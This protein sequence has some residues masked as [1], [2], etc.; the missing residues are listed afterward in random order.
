MPTVVQASRFNTLRNRVNAILGTSTSST[1]TSGYGQGTTSNAVVGTSTAPTIVD[2]DKIT[3]QDYEDLYIDIVRS[4]YHQV[5]NSYVIDDFVVGDFESNPATADKI[6]EAY[7]TGL[8]GLATNLE[9]DKFL[10]DPAQ[11]S[12]VGFTDSNG[13]DMSST[14]IGSTP[15]N[16]TIDHIFTMT[17]PTEN[18]RR[19]FFNS[20]GQVRFQ[21]NVEYTGSQAKT[22][23]WQTI[24]A[25]MG[26]ISFAA[27]STFSNSNV[28]TGYPVG[29]YSLTSSYRLCY[30]KSGGALYS[31]NDY[32]IRAREVSATV[33][34]F[35]VSFVD[36]QPNDPTYGI[37]ES[38]FGD[39]E[40]SILLAIP[41]GSVNING[42]V[43][44]TVVYS[45]SL[46]TG[47][48]ISPL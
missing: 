4:R 30:S 46:P 5:G 17:F 45:E 43:Y 36:G 2:A 11:I 29:N 14:R 41:N 42:T 12:V 47:T 23:D 6:E 38:V 35:K 34:Q 13:N 26:Q 3:A 18:A 7:I 31:R 19:H 39:F 1:P 27:N 37:D 25:N 28:G 33:I 8:E 22:V 44:D 16:G 40:S 32:E 21:G 10:V 9:T 24:I 48:I 20:G 15:W